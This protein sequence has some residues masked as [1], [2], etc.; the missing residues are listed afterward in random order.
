MEWKEA[1]GLPAVCENCSE[2][3]CYNCDHAR[4][5]WTLSPREALILRRKGL[6]NAVMRL[7]RQI[8]SI[9]EELQTLSSSNIP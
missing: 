6:T 3:D 5:R 2:E 8:Q 1:D 7:L 9:D 4:E